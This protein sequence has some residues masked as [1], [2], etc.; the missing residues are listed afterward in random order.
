M[1]ALR[2][3]TVETGRPVAD[4]P[5]RSMSSSLRELW[6]GSARLLLALSLLN[7]SNYV[8]HVVVSRFLG[9]VRYG[10]LAALL[11][12]VLVLSV[13]LSVLQTVVAKRIAS[14]RAEGLSAE[15]RSLAASTARAIYPFAVAA[16]VL[17]LVATPA[18]AALLHVAGVPAAMLAPYLLLSLLAAVPL[19][20]LQGELRF[21]A[22]AVA[23]VVGVAV[24]LG[25]GI[26]L[27][28]AGVGVTGAMLATVL[29]Q[30]S[31]LAVAAALVGLH[32]DEWRTSRAS[33]GLLRG[34]VWVALLSLGSFWLLVEA[35]LALA[36]HYLEPHAAGLYSSAGL[37]ARA[38]LFLPAAVGIVA[39][40]RFAEWGGRGPEAGRWLRGALGIVAG[41]VLC[42]LPFLVALREQ[43]TAFTFGDE[44]RD[45]SDL[46]PAL[47]A[48][49]GFMALSSILV[50][51]H[52]AAGSRAYRLVVAGVIVEAIL[53]AL[54]HRTPEQIAFVVIGVAAL[55]A[56]LLYHAASAISRWS[57]PAH[58]A[59]NG[60]LAASLAGEPSVELSLV[61][62]CHNAAPALARVLSEI[63]H[64]LE[65]LPSWEIIV[66]SDGSTDETVR[67]AESAGDRVRVLQYARRT[68]KG[69]ALRIG[70]SEAC[71]RYVGFIDADGDITP[72]AIR[73]FL[74]IMRL[75]EPDIVLGSKRH[76]LSEV[77]YPL[78][79][80]IMSWTYHKLVRLLFRVNVRDT[81]T[82]LK[83]IRRDVL[84]S[85]LPLM[86]EKRYVFDLELLVV[87]RNLGYRRVF[88]A[89]VF[90][91]Y[92]FSSQV[93]LRAVIRIVVDTLAV[94]YR[95][96]ILASYDKQA[97]AGDALG[98]GRGARSQHWVVRVDGTS[99]VTV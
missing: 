54:F 2:G 85:V 66:V 25:A 65:H 78:A 1:T 6:S 32:R 22:L 34:E 21:S 84:T 73:P 10:A 71:G 62:P 43:I 15:T 45:A 50:Y 90:V 26:G 11:A 20:V 93:D 16:A 44:F 31:S 33:F 98:Q 64:E 4:G 3:A 40:P 8:F 56:A 9:P 27:V 48:A 83:L 49:M 95:R 82:G 30:G 52:V 91:E 61:M 94:F 67:I 55:V 5:E 76:P 35:D 74:E 46:L 79:R 17:L 99:E 7:V 60:E 72:D 92:R 53:I 89:P 42:A 77:E 87:A 59:A 58:A 69:Q 70:L 57:P 23:V 12:I 51:F 86:L 19:G 41:I 28:W 68:G 38:V 80:R 63:E 47:A 14:L 13:P 39:F 36:R 18:T 75:Y 97:A 37:I 29:A 96:F 81:Q 88:E 24:R